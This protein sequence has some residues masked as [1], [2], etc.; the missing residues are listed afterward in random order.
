MFFQVTLY[1]HSFTTHFKRRSSQRLN[2]EQT[3][4]TVVKNTTADSGQKVRRFVL[5]ARAHQSI[6]HINLVF[7][8]F[9]VQ[10]FELRVQVQELPSDAVDASVQVTVFVVLFVKVLLVALPLFVAAN[11]GVLS[12]RRQ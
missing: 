10:L 7:T 1:N 8:R 11:H 2:G 9:L 5:N 6:P 3:A 4:Q 12:V